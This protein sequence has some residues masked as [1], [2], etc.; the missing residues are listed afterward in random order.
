MADFTNEESFEGT[1]LEPYEE[2]S[3]DNWGLYLLSLY[4]TI[5]TITTVGYGDISGTTEIERI[6]CI[7]IML[8]GVISFSFINGA[9][10]SIV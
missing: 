4:W 1:W 10:S 5:T 6:Y 3:D 7:V 2:Y 9:L 8:I